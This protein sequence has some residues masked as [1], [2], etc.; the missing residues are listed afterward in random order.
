MTDA[1]FTAPTDKAVAPHLLTDGQVG[2]AVANKFL[3][4]VNQMLKGSTYDE[5]TF[6][7]EGN[8]Q[9]DLSSLKGDPQQSAVL[10]SIANKI[11]N[12]DP[13]LGILQGAVERDKNGDITGFTFTDPQTHSAYENSLAAYQ[14]QGHTALEAVQNDGTSQF[15]VANIR[16]AMEISTSGA[17]NPNYGAD[18]VIVPPQ[19]SQPPV[20]SAPPSSGIGGITI[21][22][23]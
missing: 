21:N 13:A 5:N 4:E 2:D 18:G 16:G 7:A 22:G 6:I 19:P 11:E 23:Q 10:N 3:T 8:A 9:G 17:I 20:E 15:T 12:H 14:Q 1:N